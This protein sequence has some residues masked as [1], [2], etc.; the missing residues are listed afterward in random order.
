[1][2]NKYEIDGDPLR[3]VEMEETPQ[4]A[5]ALAPEVAALLKSMEETNRKLE[6]RLSTMEAAQVA[7]PGVSEA[8]P[9]AASSGFQRGSLA[10]SVTIITRPVA[11]N[12][13]LYPNATAAGTRRR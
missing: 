9:D 2:P 12:P 13:E 6:A 7:G 8:N 5:S 3:P 1:M 10:R 11:E 4:V